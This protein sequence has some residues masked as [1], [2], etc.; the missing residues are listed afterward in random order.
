MKIE[1]LKQQFMHLGLLACLVIGCTMST[2]SHANIDNSM[3]MIITSL[4]NNG[5]ARSQELANRLE[6]SKREIICLFR[7]V[8]QSIDNNNYSHNVHRICAEFQKLKENI[9]APMASEPQCATAH[10]E[11][12]RVFADFEDLIKVLNGLKGCHPN[13]RKVAAYARLNRFRHL[14]PAELA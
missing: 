12:A 4:R 6:D 3:S 8:K 11:L 7:E 5:D 1:L 9:L 13:A 10:A 2:V 14:M